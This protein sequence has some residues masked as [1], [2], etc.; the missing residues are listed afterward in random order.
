MSN[1]KD[2]LNHEKAR[3][4]Y[5]AS[6]HDAPQDQTEEPTTEH[7][8]KM[9]KIRDDIF[10][11][12]DDMK[13]AKRGKDGTPQADSWVVLEPGFSVVDSADLT[14]LVIEFDGKVLILPYGEAVR[15]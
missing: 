4:W 6:F 3:A 7:M 13:I 9:T 2:F 8:V 14:K 10:V 1:N 5:Q 11:F 12:L 15:R